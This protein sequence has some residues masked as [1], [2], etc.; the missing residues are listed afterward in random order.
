[1]GEALTRGLMPLKISSEGLPPS[2]LCENTGRRQT[3][4]SPGMLILDLPVYKDSSPRKIPPNS[5]SS[6]PLVC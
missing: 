2:L 3:S 1:M 6:L 4:K 5:K